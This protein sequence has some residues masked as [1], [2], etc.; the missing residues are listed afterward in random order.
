MNKDYTEGYLMGVNPNSDKPKTENEYY[1]DGFYQARFDWAIS[2][3]PDITAPTK[4]HKGELTNWM[5]SN[6][7][8]RRM[9]IANHDANQMM[10]F[11]GKSTCI[12]TKDF[13]TFQVSIL[14]PEISEDDIMFYYIW[15][16][17]HY[18]MGNNGFS[19]DDLKK[20]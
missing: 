10:K 14:T 13:I 9:I 20:K 5:K 2:Q 16:D 3:I 8:K 19:S 7:Y 6:E 12:L 17:E 18:L 4:L 11:F 1:L 15:K